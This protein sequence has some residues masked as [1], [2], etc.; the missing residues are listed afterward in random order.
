MIREATK[1]DA[2]AIAKIYNHYI[3]NTVITFEEKELD[4]VTL[5][6]RIKKV[7]A[8][9]FSWLVAIENEK[10]IGFAYSSKWNEREAYRHTAEVS[11]YLLHTVTSNGWG[12]Q[13]YNAIFSSLRNKSIH[14]VIG[15][16]TL[17]N[18]A[19]IAIH[20]KFGMEKVAHFKQVGFKFGEWL[21]VGYWQ[22]QLSI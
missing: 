6:E 3:Q 17:P 8:S 20:E 13:L 15:G 4:S 22:V 7:Q 12:T 11:V 9:G 14:M 1:M 2:E 19:S 16:I 5:E 21:D 18:P 10:V